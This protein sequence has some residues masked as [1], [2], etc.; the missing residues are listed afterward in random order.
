MPIYMWREEQRWQ[1][2]ANTVA[3]FP[4]K[5][6]QLDATNNCSINSTWTKQTIW[7]RFTSSSS[8]IGITIPSSKQ[9]S[10]FYSCRTKCINIPTWTR[11]NVS[12]M[13]T[14]YWTMRFFY[15]YDQNTHTK[16]FG[17]WKDSSNIIWSSTKTVS[18]SNR[19]HLA[20]WCDSSNNYKWWINWNLVFDWQATAQRF[21]NTVDWFQWENATID[22]SDLILES[23][24]RT[25]QEV[26]DYYN[27]TKSDYGL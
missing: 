3:Y 10:R 26:L 7:F 23:E 13:L 16:Q 27:Q 17:Y 6:D 14:S 18:L 22:Y 11:G 25:S 4:F 2:W 20:Y 8:K 15:K 9:T 12:S 1:P 19:F 21:I 5:D 24:L